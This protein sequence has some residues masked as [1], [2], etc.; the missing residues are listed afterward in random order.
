MHEY[1][2]AIYDL[3]GEIVKFQLSLEIKI[4]LVD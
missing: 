3:S 4:Y 2:S 1:K